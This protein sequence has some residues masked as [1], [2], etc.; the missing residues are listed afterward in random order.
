MDDKKTKINK[1]EKSSLFNFRKINSTEIGKSTIRKTHSKKITINLPDNNKEKNK[2]LKEYSIKNKNPKKITFFPS[3]TN[4]DKNLN[5]SEMCENKLSTSHK[6]I[7]NRVIPKTPLLSQN[8]TI[9]QYNPKKITKNKKPKKKLEINLP[10]FPTNRPKSKTL[11]I[12][13]S[14]RVLNTQIN[15]SN[16]IK[17]PLLLSSCNFNFDFKYLDEMENFAIDENDEPLYDKNSSFPFDLDIDN[18][19]DK[20]NKSL[21]TITIPKKNVYE[22]NVNSASRMT[23]SKHVIGI[24]SNKRN[25]NNTK[26]DDIKKITKGK[27]C[28]N[29]LN[30]DDQS[31]IFLKRNISLPKIPSLKYAKNILSSRN[32]E[33]SV[34]NFF[35]K[36]KVKTS[37]SSN[38]LAIIEESS[39]KENHNHFFKHYHYLEITISAKNKIVQKAEKITKEKKIKPVI[40]EDKNQNVK[41][42]LTCKKSF[43]TSNNTA[44]K[45][46]FEIKNKNHLEEPKK[47]FY[48]TFKKNRDN[49]SRAVSTGNNKINLNMTIYNMSTASSTTVNSKIFNGL[50]EDYLMTKEL[51][52]GSYAVVKLAINKYTREKFAIKIYKK[53]NLLDPKKRNTVKNEIN[54]L[55]QLDH[56]NIMKLYE[57]IE[58]PSFT[59][60]VLEYINGISLLEV[61]KNEKNNFL[62]EKRAINIFIQVVRGISFCQSKNIFHRDIKLENI[63]LMKDDIVKIIDFGFAIQCPKNTYQKLF[64]GSVSYMSPE[65]V[66][67]TKYIAQYSD[68]WSLGVLLYVMLYGNFPFIGDNEDELFE[69]INQAEL[70]FDDTIIVSDEIKDLLKKIFVIEPTK[71]PSLDEILND[72]L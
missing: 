18:S 54:I 70:E 36:N 16:I 41:N 67:K 63:L 49:C 30:S 64:C 26:N 56:E 12:S 44:K 55:K 37:T 15:N 20:V 10:E 62:E 43:S 13:C 72:L 28:R 14:E 5:I 52:K 27:S 6:K 19:D 39:K 59:Y 68:V 65:I 35:Y 46:L 4:K 61:M 33:K 58:N 29:L 21:K 3:K 23:K 38:P 34:K 71:R 42:T 8:R 45:L 17:S 60:L 25:K 50:I 53:E 48:N 69:K 66:N 2:N 11:H 51:G 7:F 40:I 57:V 32:E 1:V 31:S 9:Y 24:L 22:Y 47:I